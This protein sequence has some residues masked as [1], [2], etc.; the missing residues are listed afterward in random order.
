MNGIKLVVDHL[1]DA[2]NSIDTNTMHRDATQY[3][4][5]WSKSKPN[6]K[7]HA[8][9][10]PSIKKTYENSIHNMTYAFEEWGLIHG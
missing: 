7:K 2:V 5:Y 9:T 4:E 10:L 3:G 1:G 6:R 8:S